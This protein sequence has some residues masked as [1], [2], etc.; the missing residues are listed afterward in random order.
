MART[1]KIIYAQKAMESQFIYLCSQINLEE[2]M[3]ERAENQRKER[4]E[5]RK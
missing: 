2:C 3:Q 5:K 1:R 4:R